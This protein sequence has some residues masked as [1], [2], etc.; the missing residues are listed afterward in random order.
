MRQSFV[1]AVGAAFMVGP[2]PAEGQAVQVPI[3]NSRE[4]ID[5]SRPTI[6]PNSTPTFSITERFDKNKELSFEYQRNS[7]RYRSIDDDMRVKLQIAPDMD[8][9]WKG[10]MGARFTLRF[11]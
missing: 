9:K 8:V 2:A 5:I 1:I 3:Q 11:K 7:D 4:F 10:V 6:M